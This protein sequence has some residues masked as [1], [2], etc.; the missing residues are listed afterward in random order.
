MELL[1]SNWRKSILMQ[2]IKTEI[3]IKMM[4]SSS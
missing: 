2:N 3:A 1:N 4:L